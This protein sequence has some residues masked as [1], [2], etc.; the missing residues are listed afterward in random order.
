MSSLKKILAIILATSVAW[1][2]TGCAQLPTSGDIE[3]GPD[4]KSSLEND[5]LYYS[6]QG[7]EDAATQEQILLGFLNAGTGPQNDYAIAREYL[8]EEF[9]SVWKPSNRVLIRQGFPE[10]TE[11]TDQAAVVDLKVSAQ[12]N[13]LGQYQVEPADTVE[14]LTFSFVRENGQWRIS[15]AP[16][17]TTVIRPVFDVIFQSYSIY[18]YDNQLNYL[19]PDVRWFPSRASTSTRLIDALL[20]GPSAWL[21]PAVTSAIPSGTKL[22]LSSVNVTDG[23]AIVDLSAR[24]LS[25]T[26]RE[27]QLMEA[28]IRETLLQLNSVFSVRLLI[29][30]SPQDIVDIQTL[31]PSLVSTTPVAFLEDGL[32]HIDVTSTSKIIGTNAV[33][34]TF[35][36]TEFGLSADEETLLVRG[37]EGIY[38]SN[39]GKLGS[40]AKL[41]A[42]GTNFIAPVIDRQGF[43]WVSGAAPGSVLR[44]YGQSGQ[45]LPISANWMI[46]LTKYE[47]SISTEGSRALILAG[48][49]DEREIFVS[50]IVRDENGRPIELAAPIKPVAAS[51]QVVSASWVNPTSIGYLESAGDAYTNVSIQTIGGI[52]NTLP[53]IEAGSKIMGNSSS[54]AIYVLN[55]RGEFY[56]QRGISWTLIRDLVT[57]AHFPGI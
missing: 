18:F 43:S 27:K 39:Y 53:R 8:S 7:P 17:L 55:A 34:D 14:Q 50:A 33:L 48:S 9:K 20:K 1:L 11:R 10:I 47:I 37:A 36:A 25:T 52:N 22:S 46:P 2:A 4:I 21:A 26:Y 15:N 31:A 29:E 28:Q 12:V 16:H 19:V 32:S 24:A 6:P 35:G 3:T 44:V 13:S 23:Q 57:A 45:A 5:Y 38:F 30:R 54:N 51:L 40:Q 42:A 49:G 41:L 56:Q